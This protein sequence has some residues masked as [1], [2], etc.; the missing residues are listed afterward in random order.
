M[1]P[2]PWARFIHQGLCMW[3]RLRAAVVFL[4]LPGVPQGGTWP[5]LSSTEL[6]LNKILL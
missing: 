2:F 3:R 6:K 5:F 1:L 4:E